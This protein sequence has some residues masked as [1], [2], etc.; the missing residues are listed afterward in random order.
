MEVSKPSMKAAGDLLK[1]VDVE[2]QPVAVEPAGHLEF[3]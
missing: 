2:P 3:A 1:K